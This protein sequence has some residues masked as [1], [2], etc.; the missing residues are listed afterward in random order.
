MLHILD[1][2]SDSGS[3]GRPNEDAFG[4]GHSHAW[5]I[6]GATGVAD[7]ELLDAPS[8]AHWLAQTASAFF[9]EHADRYGADLAGLTRNAIEEMR[10]RFEAGRS[11]SPNGRYEL[12]SAAMALVHGDG[13]RIH[14]ANF[15]DCRLDG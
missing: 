14:C 13:A 9:A 7:S 2:I 15:A 8:D 12:P 6:D 1:A 10:R 4:R 5:V 11:R 3:A